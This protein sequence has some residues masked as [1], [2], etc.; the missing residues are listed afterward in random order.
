MDKVYQSDEIV[1]LHTFHFGVFFFT[2]TRSK[3]LFFLK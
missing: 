2:I 3:S 1:K